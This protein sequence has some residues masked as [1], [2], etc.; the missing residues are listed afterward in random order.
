[1]PAILAAGSTAV[2]RASVAA[3]LMTAV[4]SRDEQHAEAS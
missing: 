4:L 1:M 3:W 2:A